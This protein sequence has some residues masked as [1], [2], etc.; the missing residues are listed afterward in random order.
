MTRDSSARDADGLLA[1]ECANGHLTHPGHPR[2]P[3]CGEAQTT[4][5]DLADQTGTVVTWTTAHATPSGVREPN[6]LA[7]VE[8]SV[9]ERTVRTIGQTTDDVEIGDEVQPTYVEQLRDPEAGIRH[10]DSQSWD[11]Y[12]FEPIE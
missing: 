2:C 4:T 5:V 12:R 10:T 8:F 11:G 6:T 1:H 3:T 7:I 9:G